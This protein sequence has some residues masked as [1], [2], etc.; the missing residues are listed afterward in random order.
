MNAFR[1]HVLTRCYLILDDV[2]ML[3]RHFTTPKPNPAKVPHHAQGHQLFRRRR[4]HQILRPWLF[5]LIALAP[6]P[7]SFIVN[8]L[9]LCAGF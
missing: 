1:Q 4:S 3:P 8:V 5:D 9:S 2:L 7:F 6:P